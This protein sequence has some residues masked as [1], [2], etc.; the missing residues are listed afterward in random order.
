MELAFYC[1]WWGLDHLEPDAMVD[2]VAASG[3]DG[4][5]TYVP[6]TSDGRRRL[7]RAIDAA[8]LSCIAHCYEASGAPDEWA[9]GY[10]TLLQRAA[11]MDPVF[12]NSHTGRDHWDQ[13]AVDRL[14]DIG[15]EVEAASGVTILHETHRSRF[16]YSAAVTASYLER[17]PEL[18]LTADL[19]HWACVSESLLEDQQHHLE[20][21]LARSVHVHARVGSAQSAQ[22]PDVRHPRWKHELDVHVH[23]WRRIHAHRL[24]AGAEVMTITTEFGPPPYAPVDIDTG[25]PLT[26][27]LELDVWMREHLRHALTPAP[28]DQHEEPTT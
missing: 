19:S 4:I 3:F 5:E 9:A 11:D 17:W 2:L 13:R 8:G 26:E 1:P 6:A 10:R 25:E 24:A 12:V 14:L 15:F 28:A 16:P 20:P 7:R 23:W 27:F 18:R 21:A 22:V